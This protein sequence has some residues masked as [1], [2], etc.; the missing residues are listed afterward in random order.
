MLCGC[1]SPQKTPA[2]TA[3]QEKMLKSNKTNEPQAYVNSKSHDAKAGLVDLEE[4]VLNWAK[5]IFDTTKTNKEAKIKKKYLSYNINWTKLF[6][7]SS[8]PT[9][10]IHGAR[11]N[12]ISNPKDEKVLFKTTFTNTTQ[13][14]Q[15]YSFKTE[16]ATRSTSTVII[17]R[18]VCRGTEVSLKL[19]T[20]CEVV[21]ANAGFHQ[22]V[23]LNHIGENTNEEELGWGVDSTVRVPPNSETVAELVI[24]EDI[25]SRDFHIENRLSGKVLVTITNMKEN[26]SLVTVVEGNVADI[27]RGMTDYAAKGFT[28]EG[29]QITKY[30]TRGTCIF[31][32]GIEQKVRITETPLRGY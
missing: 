4:I 6:Q 12:V 16:R 31:R 29:N 13:R 20:P 24:I 26:N 15:E 27:I 30:E 28:F 18:G 9:Y 17:E 11:P 2:F 10:S 25:V 7:E 19:K 21:E 23:M 3:E 32:Y 5:V 22:E 14:E 8:E 1:L